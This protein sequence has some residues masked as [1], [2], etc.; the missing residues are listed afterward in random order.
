MKSVFLCLQQIVMNEIYSN[1]F[2]IPCTYMGAQPL[3]TSP[4]SIYLSIK[5]ERQYNTDYEVAKCKVPE[6]RYEKTIFQIKSIY[7]LLAKYGVSLL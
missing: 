7:Y 1:N 2:Q 4:L 3:N 6:K 5:K